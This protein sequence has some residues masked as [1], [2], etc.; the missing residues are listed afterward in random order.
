MAEAIVGRKTLIGL[1]GEDDSRAGHP[2][3][4]LA[5]DEM[6]HYV[7]GTERFRAFVATRETLADV[8]QQRMQRRRRCPQNVYRFL[9]I[10]AHAVALLVSCGINEN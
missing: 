4:F 5:V 8:I 3:G 2:I 1:I 7:K 6:T 10:E 9:E